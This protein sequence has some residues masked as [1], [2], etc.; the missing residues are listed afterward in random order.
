MVWRRGGRVLSP[1]GA[2]ARPAPTPVR[3]IAALRAAGR[4]KGAHS[5]GRATAPRG[6]TRPT[7]VCAFMNNPAQGN[8]QGIA[9]SPDG[10][11]ALVVSALHHPRSGR[12][13]AGSVRSRR[14]PNVRSVQGRAGSDA[15]VDERRGQ[16]PVGKPRLAIN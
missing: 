8:L 1:R 4:T 16:D 6:A 13:R 2:V 10:T 14:K 9:A 3:R 15:R 5:A 11:K 7:T 12:G